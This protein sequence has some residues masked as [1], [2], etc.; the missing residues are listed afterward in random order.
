M[1][2]WRFEIFMIKFDENFLQ[3]ANTFPSKILFHIANFA[4][5][6]LFNKYFIS[7]SFPDLF[8][9]IIKHISLKHKSSTFK[10][11]K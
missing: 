3:F 6:L 8:F 4:L 7:F 10:N 11:K 9:L 5:L 1:D 2:I